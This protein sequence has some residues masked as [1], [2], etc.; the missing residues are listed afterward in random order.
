M[1]FV[2]ELKWPRMAI[3]LTCL[4]INIAVLLTVGTRN[5]EY[6]RNYRAAGT[7]DGNSYVRLGEN[8][9]LRGEYSRLTEPP[10][11]PNMNR[12]PLY[13]I[14]A[15]GLFLAF[16]PGGIYAVQ[17]VFHALSCVLLFE[18]GAICF[19]R[20]AGFWA[21]I[22]LAVNF[23]F[24]DANLKPLSEV[25]FTLLVLAGVRL[26]LEPLTSKPLTSNDSGHSAA[27]QVSLSGLCF[28][29]SIVTR[30]VGL[31]LPILCLAALTVS[32]LAS[33]KPIRTMVWLV[34]F[35]VC[36][37]LPAA[38]WMVRNQQVFGLPR[39][40]STDA[41]I[42][43]YYLGTAAYQ[44]HHGISREEAHAMIRA[45]YGL[46][47]FRDL[48][49]F[50]VYGGNI[51]DLYYPA[52]RAAVPILKKYPAATVGAGAI[53]VAKALSGHTG[54][55]LANALALEWHRP[56]FGRLV[57][58]D[59]EALKVFFSNNPL[60]WTV[61]VWELVLNFA[62]LLLAVFAVLVMVLHPTRHKLCEWLLVLFAA[63]FCAMPALYAFVASCR[64]ATPAWPF[65]LLLA[66]S[67]VDRGKTAEATQED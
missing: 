56:G 38:G 55:S 62:S 17:A 7:K 1:S 20:Q 66:A 30:P 37:Y 35:A 42:S 57:K 50:D 13:P 45:E 5:P 63:Y 11:S 34:L 41:E 36:S 48:H 15:G 60:L 67:A 64:A 31:Y 9:Y 8:I 61:V 47:S 12:P 18:I 49:N 39:L 51:R 23:I 46:G 32:G 33:R 28:G 14:I 3:F 4:A 10:Y 65:I 43:V 40:T 21:A 44:I 26:I 22:L 53:G 54:S 25:T 2:T 6:M 19:S 24:I 59:K 16:G 58:G 52:K 29:L 27:W